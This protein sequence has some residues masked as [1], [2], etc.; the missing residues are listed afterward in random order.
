MSEPESSPPLAYFLT[1]TI[2]GSWLHGDP[3]GSVD[4][5]WNAPNSLRLAP[6]ERRTR[7]EARRL[8]QSRPV[9]LDAELRHA[10]DGAIRETC[11]TRGWLLHALHVRTNHVHA[12]VTAPVA[13]ER[14]V[15]TFK[16][17]G[18]RV[19]REAGLSNQDRLWTR[20]GSTRYLWDEEALAAAC[21]YVIE[22][23]GEMLD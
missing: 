8:S 23:Q 15:A 22:G 18:T 17:N 13:P 21:V 9:R 4:R 2:Y 3:R 7:F 10:I 1:W 14:V 6:D 20:H 11:A 12:V 16:A 5:R 19:A